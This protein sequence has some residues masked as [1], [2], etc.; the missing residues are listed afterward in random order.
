MIL[1]LFAKYISAIPYVNIINKTI[2]FDDV[3]IPLYKISTQKINKTG[4]LDIIILFIIFK[5][6]LDA[7]TIAKRHRFTAKFRNKNNAL[8]VDFM[9]TVCIVST[10]KRANGQ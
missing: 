9:Y 10:T 3:V 6:T 4:M 2:K 8:F 7:Q 5:V 1:S